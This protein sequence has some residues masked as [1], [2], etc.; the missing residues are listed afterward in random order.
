MTLFASPLIP[1][2]VPGAQRIRLTGFFRNLGFVVTRCGLTVFNA[3][4]ESAVL[5]VTRV[6]PAD[7]DL[8]KDDPGFEDSWSCDCRSDKD[9]AGGCTGSS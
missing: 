6:V 5:E 7:L 9:T 8:L 4:M 2:R 3:N 1:F